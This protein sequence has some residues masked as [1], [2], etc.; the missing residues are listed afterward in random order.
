MTHFVKSYATVEC[1]V[2]GLSKVCNSENFS[3]RQIKNFKNSRPVIC[4]VCSSK[5]KAEN[6]KLPI[7]MPLD[8]VTGN[9]ITGESES[10]CL[11]GIFGGG[12]RGFNRV[13]VSNPEVLPIS[14]FRYYHSFLTDKE[15]E[16]IM[17]IIDSNPW[18]NAV[19]RRQQFYGEIYYHTIH[20]VPEIQP[21]FSCDKIGE[22]S[23]KNVGL[24][25]S[26]FQFLIDKFYAG[27]FV[28]AG[29]NDG[30]STNHIF[31][32]DKSSF[33]TQILVN[34]YVGETGI[35]SHFE[36]EQAFGPV[37]ATISLLNPIYMT[38]EKPVD[39]NNSCLDFLGQT[40]VLLEK[41]SLFIMHDDC[42]YKW[43]HAITRHR[44]VPLVVTENKGFDET[45]FRMIQRDSKY[46]R[47]SLTIRHLLPGRK[48]VE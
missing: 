8:P 18:K 40:K 15:A 3:V 43:R 27:I 19:K 26:P 21:K 12:G 36:D 37:I 2:C 7:R 30:H 31:G 29:L 46:R 11:S 23:A 16:R 44:K 41:N 25:M 10:D 24:D 22:K 9:L 20:D 34:E 13:Y 28:D 39:H 38:L 1:R 47:V 4:Y 32:S 5:E 33:P 35:S 45:K 42:R 6:N 48:Q 14:G 17:D